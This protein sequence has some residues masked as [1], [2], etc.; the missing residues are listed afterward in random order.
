MLCRETLPTG[1]SDPQG[2][3]RKGE[4]GPEKPLAPKTTCAPPG[5]N[6]GELAAA[7]PGPGEHRRG[8]AGLRT[9]LSG[10]ESGSRRPA[11]EG[12]GKALNTEPWLARAASRASILMGSAAASEEEEPPSAPPET[13]EEK[14]RSSLSPEGPGRLGERRT[15]AD[16]SDFPSENKGNEKHVRE[17]HGPTGQCPRRAGGGPGD[18]AG[19]RER[20][21]VPVE[22]S[23]RL[24]L[25]RYRRPGAAGRGR[26]R[27][28]PGAAATRPPRIGPAAVPEAEASRERARL[29]RAR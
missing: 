26:P 23:R 19:P 25:W 24:P 6:R 21:A 11:L 3:Q 16:D 28:R 8:S 2:H 17:R 27:L 1:A 14:R 7:T 4:R 9:L 13:A 10:W 29:S 18:P 20:L 5:S 22:A 15:G 12:R